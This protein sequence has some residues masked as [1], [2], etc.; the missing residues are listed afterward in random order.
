[1]WLLKYDLWKRTAHNERKVY[2]QMHFATWQ[3]ITYYY[4]VF[5]MMKNKQKL[6]FSDYYKSITP[7]RKKQ[8]KMLNIS[9]EP[10]SLAK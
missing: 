8:H 2:N 9:F 3:M 6:Y 7:V 1:M 10:F 5:V 4:A